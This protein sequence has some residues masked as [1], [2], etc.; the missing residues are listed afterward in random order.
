VSRW[1]DE[2]RRVRR[3]VE[4]Q[5]VED[6]S[7]HVVDSLAVAILTSEVLELEKEV[8]ELLDDLRVSL[9]GKPEIDI[10]SIE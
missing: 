3:N 6:V 2:A 5:C 4:L 8:P 9:E 1:I 10:R 7:K